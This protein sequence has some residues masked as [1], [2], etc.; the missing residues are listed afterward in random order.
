MGS[1]I[2]FKSVTYAQRASR[3]L[4]QNGIGSD[5]VRTQAIL[6]GGSCSYALKVKP[7]ALQRAASVLRGSGIP[8][9]KLYAADRFGNYV[10]AN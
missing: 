8:F 3:V 9:G 10:E 1:L 6:G 7:Q 5:M 2:V 4:A